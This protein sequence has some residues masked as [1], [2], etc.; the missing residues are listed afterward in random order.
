[1]AFD[2]NKIAADIIA[3]LQKV[4]SKKWSEGSAFAIQRAKD[5]A[6]QTALLIPLE[7]TGGLDKQGLA[8]AAGRIK[9]Q[10]RQFALT[11]ANLIV[12]AAA[13]LFDAIIGVIWTAVS[14]ALNGIG[15]GNLLPAKPSF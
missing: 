13:A 14:G 6:E 8:F 2:V 4:G 9:E 5:L 7:A 11:L 3:A 10:A 12:A 15:L 1:M